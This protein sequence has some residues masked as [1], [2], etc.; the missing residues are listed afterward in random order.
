MVVVLTPSIH[1]TPFVFHRKPK[2]LVVIMGK[3]GKH[4][5]SLL[6]I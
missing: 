2:L 6:R 5:M 1:T 3:T 4:E